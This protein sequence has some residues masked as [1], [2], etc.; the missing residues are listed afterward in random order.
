VD[1]AKYSKDLNGYILKK[2]ILFSKC[3]NEFIDCDIF[4]LVMTDKF[5]AWEYQVKRLF[6]LVEINL[7][8]PLWYS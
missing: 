2:S 3:Q 5:E 8:W 7:S 4:D 6:C 1:P